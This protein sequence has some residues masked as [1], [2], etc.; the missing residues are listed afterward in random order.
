MTD[1]LA[2][3]VVSGL[4]LKAT[5]SQVESLVRKAV[6]PLAEQAVSDALTPDVLEEVRL[7]AVE[8]VAAEVSVDETAKSETAKGED[9]VHELRFKSLPQFV[10]EYVLPNWRHSQNQ[11]ARWCARW[12]EHSEAILH[13]EAL[14]E[15]F[16]ELRLDVS[17]TSVSTFL[18]QYFLPH[19]SVL[20]SPSGPFWLCSAELGRTAHRQPPVWEH[21]Q[22]P[23]GLFAVAD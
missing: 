19:M 12:W 9:V 13:L 5:K 8:A 18:L 11:D 4:L 16:E 7:A 6:R 23:G 21:E 3:T 22:P 15:S 2:H 17:G 14:W 10:D 20:T 1:E